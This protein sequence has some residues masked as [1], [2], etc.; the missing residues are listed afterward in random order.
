MP[1]KKVRVNITLSENILQSIDM[2]A[3]SFGYSRS[4]YITM[5]ENYVSRNLWT[6]DESPYGDPH[7]KMPIGYGY[8]EEY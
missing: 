3:K 7:E 6:D 8:C 2:H 5:L 4:A 1:D